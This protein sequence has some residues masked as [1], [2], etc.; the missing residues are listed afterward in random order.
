MGGLSALLSLLSLVGLVGFLGGIAFIVISASQGRP[1]RA[2]ISIALAGLVVFL[3]FSVISSGIIIVQ[4]QE[5]AVVFNVITGDLQEP[6]LSAGTHVVIPLLYE[7]TIYPVRQQEYTMTDESGEGAQVGQDAVI[8]RTSDGQEVRLDVTVLYNLD[9]AQ[10]NLVHRRWQRTYEAQFV[11]PTVRNVVRTVVSEYEAE[12]V[13]GEDRSE[14]E[15]QIETTIREGFQREGLELTGL[16]VRAVNF[17]PEFAEAIERKEIEAQELARAQTE[18]ERVETQ[19]RGQA[20]ASIERA[21]GEAQ[22]V[23][24]NAQA[25]AEALR[26]VSEQIAANPS[27][28]QYEYVQRLSENIQLALVPS[29][30]PF[31]FDFNSLAEGN[32]DFVAPTVPEAIVPEIEETAEPD[33]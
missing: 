21:R 27:L 16:L 25:Q 9:A 13:Y 30:S 6:P 31:L 32:P 33:N 14:L 20:N 15:G 8:A 7:F 29:N 2:G 5:R 22:A 17:R 4:P 28:I 3:L 1:V 11:R 12:G 10:L 23:V 18:A 24:L 26:L 19:A